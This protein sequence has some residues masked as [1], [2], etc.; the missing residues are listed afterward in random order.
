MKHK[1]S[2]FAATSLVLTALLSYPTV[3]QATEMIHTPIN[4][5]FGGS[6]LNGPVLLNSA[7]AQNHFTASSS[8]SSYSGYTA[9]SALDN[10]NQ[11]LQSMILDRIATSVTGSIFDANGK[12]KAGIVDTTAFSISIV[13]AGSGILKIT[14]TDKATGASTTFE[15]STAP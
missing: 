7:N 1:I 14:T 10:F 13:D 4:P 2:K 12:L 8:K 15:I 9:P 6:P 3:N 11:R 5:S